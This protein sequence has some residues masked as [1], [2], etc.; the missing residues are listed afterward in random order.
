[1]N[2]APIK[3]SHLQHNNGEKPMPEKAK[4]FAVTLASLE[5]GAFNDTLSREA[6]ELIGDMSNHAAAYGG[7]AKGRISIALD[8]TLKDGIFEINAEKKIT[9]PK[10]KKSHSIF[11]A[12]K[13]NNL[14]EENPRQRKFEF[15]GKV[16]PIQS[17]QD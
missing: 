13:D 4:S 11:W 15:D 9:P 6:Q 1:M 14:T 10:E 5:G 3:K 8:I 7:N 2:V 16:A 17:G 12:D